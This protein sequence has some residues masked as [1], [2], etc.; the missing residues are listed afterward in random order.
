M[1]DHVTNSLQS[2]INGLKNLPALPEASI[3]ILDAVN[4]PDVEI[5]KLV[6][7]LSLSPALVAR[8]LGLANSAYFGQPRHIKDLRSAIIQVLGLR[9]VRSLAV[10]VVLNVQLDASKCKNFDTR[11]FWLH[12]LMTAVTAQKLAAGS[13]IEDISPATVYTSGLLLHIGLLVMAYL[14][15]EELDEVLSTE[16]KSYLAINEA[17]SLQLGLSHYQIGY[18]LLNKWQLPDIYQDVLRRFDEVDWTGY[19]AR[20]LSILRASQQICCALL[21]GHGKDDDQL[22]LIADAAELSLELVRKVFYEIRDSQENIEKLAR[23]LGS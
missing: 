21:E 2:K 6:E 9:L 4:D 16:S 7:V 23:V 19:S 18:L 8:F 20:L 5:E 3:R 11:Y 15:P 12:S 10:G 14:F 17:L 22:E 1:I 13:R